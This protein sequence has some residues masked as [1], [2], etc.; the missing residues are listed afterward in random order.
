MVRSKYNINADF[1]RQTYQLLCLRS[2]KAQALFFINRG[3][4]NP[5]PVE[6][7]VEVCGGN[8]FDEE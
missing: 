6:R 5:R 3:L 8:L 7:L 4:N 2:D 1:V